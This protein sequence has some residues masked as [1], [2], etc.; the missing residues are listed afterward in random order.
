MVGL[1]ERRPGLRLA[2]IAITLFFTIWPFVSV[3]RTRPEPVPLALL[4]V[5]WATFGVVLA[6]LFRVSPFGRLEDRIVLLPAIVILTTVAVLTT[7]VFGLSEATALY[8]YAGVSSARLVPSSWS[9]RAIAVIA[10][11]AGA[12]AS[13][14]AGDP[15]AGVAVGVTVGTISL[16]LSSLSALA[17]LNR[18]LE[19]ARHELAETAVA[20]ERA[21]IARDLHDTLGHSLSVIALKS[22]LARRVVRQDPDRAEAEI[23][24]VER[25]AREALASVRDT[26]TGYRQPTLAMELAGAREALRVAGIDGRVEPAPEDLPRHVDA[27]LGWAVR[28]GVTNVLRHSEARRATIRVLAEDG[29]RGVEIVDDGRGDGDEVAAEGNGLAGLRERASRLGGAIEAAR[30]PGGGFRLCVSVPVEEVSA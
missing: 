26:V 30:L 11:L 13:Y 5:G 25:T 23:G 8:Y 18:E 24:D 12:S 9:L 3:M 21:R 17:R 19:A 10:V 14:Q 7:V 16:T 4:L 1:A 15:S 22:E 20:E 27:L 6:L 28:E 29:R 2:F